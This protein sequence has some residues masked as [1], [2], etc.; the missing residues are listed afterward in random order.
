MDKGKSNGMD[1]LVKKVLDRPVVWL[2]SNRPQKS[3]DSGTVSD[4]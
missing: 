1:V 2:G 4:G 3:I